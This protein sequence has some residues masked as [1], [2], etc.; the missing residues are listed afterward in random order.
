MSNLKKVFLYVKNKGII[1]IKKVG[2]KHYHIYVFLIPLICVKSE[3]SSKRINLWLFEQLFSYREVSD[4]FCIKFLFWNVK[5]MKKSN[6][7]G[8]SETLQYISNVTDKDCSI[9]I[10]KIN[11]HLTSIFPWMRCERIYIKDSKKT[12]EYLDQIDATKLPKATGEFRYFQLRMLEFMKEMNQI[13]DQEG[14]HPMLG[15]GGLIGAIRHGGFIPWD[16]DVD[17]EMMRDEYEKLKRF[18]KGRYL[19]IDTSL[20]NDWLQYCKLIDNELQKTDGNIIVVSEF[21]DALRVYKG[22]SL[23]DAICLDFLPW[24]YINPLIPEERYKQYWAKMRTNLFTKRTCYRDVFNRIQ[25]ELNKSEM[26]AMYSDRFYYGLGNWAF[27]GYKYSGLRDVSILFPY[28]KIKFEDT[29][30]YAPNDVD[31]WLKKQYEGDY[32]SIPNKIDALAHIQAI[33][34]YLIKSGRH[35]YIDCKCIFKKSNP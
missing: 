23:E 22:T 17:F 10:K 3:G 5:I 27:R 8:L 31:S 13:L 4:G 30:F 34:Q 2:L 26:F 28:Q 19:F 6:F 9:L 18:L 21:I 14:F 11:K 33:N 35:Y 24:D 12:R 25:N 7:R 32:M 20:C 1:G 15:G 16:D 29:E